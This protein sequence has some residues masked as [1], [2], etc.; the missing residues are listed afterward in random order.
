[1]KRA[2]KVNAP[3]HPSHMYLCSNCVGGVVSNLWVQIYTA[4]GIKPICHNCA[5]KVNKHESLHKWVITSA[6]NKGVVK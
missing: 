2:E 5:S 1:M 6:N 4:R 3:L